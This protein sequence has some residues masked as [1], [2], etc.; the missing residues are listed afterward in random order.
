MLLACGQNARGETPCCTITS[1]NLKRGTVTA[2][3]NATGREFT[4][5]VNNSAL[6]HSLKAGQAVYAN[7]ATKQVSVDGLQPCCNIVSVATSPAG[8]AQSGNKVKPG[9]PCCTITSINL[10]TGLVTAVENA[11]GRSFQ[12]KVANAALLK[13][14]KTGQGVYANFATRQVSVDGATPCCGISSISAAPGATP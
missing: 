7:F 6:L 9:A 8:A 11:T 5:K 12:F 10:K 13:A 14:M 3:E 4:F 1:I 2:V